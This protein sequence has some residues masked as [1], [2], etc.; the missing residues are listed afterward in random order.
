[1]NKRGGKTYHR[2]GGGSKTVFW[3][4]VL[5]YVFPS[6]EFST[7]PLFFSEVFNSEIILF[8]FVLISVSMVINSVR[9]KVLAVM[10]CVVPVMN[11][12]GSFAFRMAVQNSEGPHFAGAHLCVLREAGSCEPFRQNALVS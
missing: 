3:G 7:P 12:Q 10:L 9:I 5:W 4:G 11:S 2:W 8:R 6:P 1:M